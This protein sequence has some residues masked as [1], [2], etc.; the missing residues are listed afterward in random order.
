MRT[1][2]VTRLIP[3]LSNPTVKVGD[4]VFASTVIARSSRPARQVVLAVAE[5]LG[6]GG[7]LDRVMIKAVG[8]TL[9]PDEPYARG[10]GMFGSGRRAKAPEHGRLAAVYPLL[11]AAVLEVASPPL[12]VPALVQGNVMDVAYSRAITIE[13]E[14]DVLWGAVAWGAEGRGVLR[15]YD[16]LSGATVPDSVYYTTRAIT[17]ALLKE[18]RN[19]GVRMLVGP[20]ASSSDWHAY[21]AGQTAGAITN[22]TS[23]WIA[24][25]M[26]LP[27]DVT[28]ALVQ[29]FGSSPMHLGATEM[30]RGHE[31]GVAS[32]L[33]HPVTGRMAFR[34]QLVFQADDA[35]TA[36]GTEDP[37]DRA[38]QVGRPAIVLRAPA[39]G[40]VVATESLPDPLYRL[41]TGARAAVA[42]VSSPNLA[43]IAIPRVNLEPIAD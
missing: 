37:M 18:A 14:G 43:P 15:A 12:E 20:G 1:R 34:P 2:R 36:G 42:R 33:L 21:A 22:G 25:T 32:L 31:G 16:S 30:L 7:H 35:S 19:R 23:G 6:L 4:P 13:V 26:G 39:Q 17:T 8:E 41:P 3:P 9:E 11:G 28:V 27:T 24:T 40:A 10:H 38:L 5:E 29:G